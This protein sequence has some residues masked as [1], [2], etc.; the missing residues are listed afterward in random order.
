[1]FLSGKILEVFVLDK[2]YTGLQVI[3]LKNW[4][5]R[6]FVGH[7][8]NLRSISNHPGLKGPSIYFLLSSDQ[9]EESGNFQVYIGE[10]EDFSHRISGHKSKAWWDKFICF[11]SANR[12][13]T[14]AHVKYL[15]KKFYKELSGED[16]SIDIENSQPPTGARL[17][18]SDM[19]FLEGFAENMRFIFKTMGFDYFEAYEQPESKAEK[20]SS[21]NFRDYSS[22]NGKRFTLGVPLTDLKSKM[23]VEA[24]K[25]I[26]EKGSYITANPRQSFI[27][28]SYHKKW[29]SV[30]ES[31][32]KESVSGRDDVYRLTEDV[33]LDSP[34]PAGS[35]VSARR[36]NGPKHWKCAETG[37]SFRALQREVFEQAA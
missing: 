36:F 19:C 30:V 22:L 28:T 24:G 16:I 3:D 10:T 20:D 26:L 32:L 25:C 27:G 12:S 4:S 5:G 13:L 21:E 8:K 29:R 23:R 37:M 14:K 2:E 1:M 11:S 31:Q 35:L 7:R 17:P 33:I 15:E 6:A 34:S 18:N 9:N